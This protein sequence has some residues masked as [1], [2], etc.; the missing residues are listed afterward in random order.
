MQ[1]GKTFLT[2]PF[3]KP[4]GDVLRSIDFSVLPEVERIVRADE[5]AGDRFEYKLLSGPNQVVF[6]ASQLL[7]GK[8]ILNTL[9]QRDNRKDLQYVAVETVVFQGKES[10]HAARGQ[11]VRVRWGGTGKPRFQSEAEAKEHEQDSWVML[12]YFETCENAHEAMENF[13][14][15]VKSS[16]VVVEISDADALGFV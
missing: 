14:R 13:T 9:N 2:A 10:G 6:L 15:D 8:P 5:R 3:D 4:D 7:N 16:S 11:A 1:E 12:I